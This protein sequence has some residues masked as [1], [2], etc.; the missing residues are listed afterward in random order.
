MRSKHSDAF[1]NDCVEKYRAGTSL[2]DVVSEFKISQSVVWRAIKKAGAERSR[3]IPL[4]EPDICAR[5]IAGESPEAL[6]AAFNVSTMPIE[7]ILTEHKIQRRT[8]SAANVVRLARLT[9]EE[10]RRN[11]AAAHAA[12]RGRPN[13]LEALERAA[14]TRQV[15]MTGRMSSTETVLAGMLRERGID[16]IPQVAIG[17]YNCDIGAA[18]VAV[19]VFGGKWHWHGAHI[20]RSPQRIRHILDAGWHMLAVRIAPV[21]DPLTASTADYIAAYIKQASSDPAAIRQYRVVRSNGDL[22]AAGSAQD[23]DFSIVSAFKNARDATTG[24][25]VRVPK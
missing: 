1:I 12:K 4:P 17:P 8:R 5:Y 10:R 6:A 19:E 23:D 21:G 13:T 3:R 2:T 9:P 25:Y 16:S 22:I 18:P 20:A 15:K 11:A 14:M 24:R 7:R